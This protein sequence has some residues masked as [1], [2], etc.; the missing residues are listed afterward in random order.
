MSFMTAEVARTKGD[1]SKF[2]SVPFFNKGRISTLRDVL[3]P[4]N[5]SNKS[6]SGIA[7]LDFEWNQ[8]VTATSA[9]YVPVG[10]ITPFWHVPDTY[11]D[12]AG[13]DAALKIIEGDFCAA[14]DLAIRWKVLGDVAAAAGCVRILTAWSTQVMPATKPNTATGPLVWCNRWPLMIEAAMLVSDYAGYTPALNTALKNL[15][16]AGQMLSLAY[17]NGNNTATWGV[18]YEI[19]AASFLRDRPMFDRAIRRWYSLFDQTI[20]NNIP[21]DEVRREGGSQGN[22]STGLWYS[23]YTVYAFTIAAE[24]ARFN[25]EWLY[26]HA[27]P[28]GST[29]RG[30]VEQV[31]FWTRYPET[32]KYNTSG[33]PSTTMR[34]LPHDEILHALWPSAESLWIIN[35]FPSGNDRDSTGIRNAVLAYRDRPLYG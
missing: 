13:Q 24:W 2:G 27:G 12:P 19:A 7:R 35:R 33:T 15:T 26:D 28:D 31:R 25:G 17:S 1:R 10:P 11:G 3:G 29:F 9:A 32:F 5:G 8:R 18:V 30:L 4:L 23:N 34:S 14:A 21:V 6:S 16:R 22:G 20:E